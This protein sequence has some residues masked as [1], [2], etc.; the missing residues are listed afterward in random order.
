MK[1]SKQPLRVMSIMAHQ[2]DFEFNAGGTFALLRETLGDR[3]K[4][5]V[6]TT[7]NGASGHH[8]MS[9]AETVAR[10]DREAR[11]SAALIGAE[12]QCLKTLD[13]NVVGDGQFLI[14]RNLLGGLWNAIR[15]F[16]ADV[17]FCPPIV[18]DPLAGIHIDHEQTAIA[19]R[20]VGYQLSVPRAYLTLEGEVD[21]QYRSPLIINVDD[22]YNR[23]TQADVR[24]DIRSVYDLKLKMSLCH[25]SQVLEWLPFVNDNGDTTEEDWAARFKLRHEQINERYSAGDE[26]LSEYFQITRWGRAPRAGELEQLFPNRIPSENSR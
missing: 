21:L 4:L 2:D 19:V 6:L 18:T 25:T 14:S 1:Q 15:H 3:V 22:P 26:I 20:Y 9:A 5:G 24:Q 11:A 10:R 8:L 16:K 23:S 13:G 7:T 17:I 12:Y